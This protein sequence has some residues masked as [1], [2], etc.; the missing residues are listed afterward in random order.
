M[1]KCI[2]IRLE[3]MKKD[4]IQNEICNNIVNME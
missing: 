4:E 2:R 3:K 1:L